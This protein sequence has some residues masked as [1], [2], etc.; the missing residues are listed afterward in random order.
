MFILVSLTL[1][2]LLLIEGTLSMR[3]WDSRSGDNR[4]ILS[5]A[6]WEY[7]H[8]CSVRP[9]IHHL[10]DQ[11][12]V[13]S[14]E[15]VS[16]SNLHLLYN[17]KIVLKLENVWLLES[18]STVEN[19]QKW[20]QQQDQSGRSLLLNQQQISSV[21]GAQPCEVC[22]LSR[23]TFGHSIADSAVTWVILRSYVHILTAS[24][25]SFVYR[26]HLHQVESHMQ[27]GQFIQDQREDCGLFRSISS[28]FCMSIGPHRKT[29]DKK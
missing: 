7:L 3:W 21:C 6:K 20:L 10:M 5:R 1:E 22:S 28:V 29:R 8:L 15:Q 9:R 26:L 14:N 12:Y 11:I 24:E 13:K 25:I 17:V 4:W 2:S 16:E 19:L 18:F 23:R 27:A